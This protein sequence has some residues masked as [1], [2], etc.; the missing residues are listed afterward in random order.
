MVRDCELISFFFDCLDEQGAASSCSFDLRH[1]PGWNN[2]YDSCS[3]ASIHTLMP[4]T[5]V[6][7]SMSY[8]R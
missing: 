5:A 3:D 1:R 6:C 7:R 2:N 8:K 4:V